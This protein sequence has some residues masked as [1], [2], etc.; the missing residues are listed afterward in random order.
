MEKFITQKILH[1]IKTIKLFSQLQGQ[2]KH[3]SKNKHNNEVRHLTKGPQQKVDSYLGLL[4]FLYQ[5]RDLPAILLL[6]KQ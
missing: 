4:I 1:N 6:L 5:L 3:E 2:I